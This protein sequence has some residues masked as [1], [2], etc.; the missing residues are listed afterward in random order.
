MET[1][2]F[3][4]NYHHL[5]YLNVRA[6][7][8][9]RGRTRTYSTGATRWHRVYVVFCNPPRHGVRRRNNPLLWKTKFDHRRYSFQGIIHFVTKTLWANKCTPTKTFFTCQTQNIFYF[10]HAPKSKMSATACTDLVNFWARFDPTHPSV[11]TAKNSGVSF[12][13]PWPR[14]CL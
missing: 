4:I 8:H 1:G 2:K 11:W 12:M 3:D 13:G 9:R 5:S 10:F 7:W 6:L 14:I